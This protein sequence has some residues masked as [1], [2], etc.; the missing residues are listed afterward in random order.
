MQ[1]YV[2]LQ[3]KKS[4]ISGAIASALLM[5]GAYA[6]ENESVDEKAQDVERIIVTAAKRSQTLQET[7]IAVSVTSDIAI[8]QAAI[9]D[10]GDLQTLVPTLR[11][12]SGSRTF[13]QS[14]SIRGFGS[15]TLLGTE[16]SVG[17]FVDGVFRS[18]S[19]GALSDLP[20]LERVEV[21]SGPQSTLFGK[22]ASAGVVSIVTAAPSYE[23]EGRVELTFGKYNQRI[24]DGYVS[25][26]LTDDLAVMVSGNVHKRDGYT[27]AL[28]PNEPDQDNQ[29]RWGLRGQLLWEPTADTT[30]RFIVDYSDVEEVCCY[31]PNVANGPTAA[32]IIALGGIINDD[33]DPFARQSPVFN[34]ATNEIKDSGVS[35]HVEVNFDD[36]VFTSIT[37]YRSNKVK[38]GGNSGGTS[39]PLAINVSTQ[40]TEIDA[41]SQEFRLTSDTEDRL[42]WIVGGF[43]YDEDASDEGGLLYGPGL[44]PYVDLLTGGI[45]ALVEA[46]FGLPT[47]TFLSE[48]VRE[49]T[50]KGQQNTDYSL[51]G[52]LDYQFTDSLT[53]TLGL[54]YTKDKKEAYLSELENNDVFSAINSN[55]LIGA[56]LGGL[57]GLQ[58]RPPVVEFPNAVE[59]G[60]SDDSDTTYQLRLAYK[61][62]DNMNFY[63]SRATG[64]KSSAWDLSNFSRPSRDL[65][66]ALTQAGANS[67]NPRYGSR[68]STPEYSTVNEIGA[69]V[70]YKEFAFNLAV[71]QQTL[72]DFQVR[73][74]DGIDFAQANAGET[75][76]DGFE[77]DMRYSPTENWTFTFAGT[78][79]NP[80]YDDFSNAPPLP[81]SPTD[82][83][84]R[85]L[86]EDLS[87]TTPTNIPEKSIALGAVYTTPLD[88]GELYV[89]ADYQYESEVTISTAFPPTWQP[90]G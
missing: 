24:I 19:T 49:I 46:N 41:L 56:G 90:W 34:A 86:P 32:A 10:I 37:A 12:S 71:F 23:N 25:G 4:A 21:L 87:G 89:R 39:I 22:N 54:N 84:G 13:S 57:V 2:F 77:F 6:Q 64:F 81:T 51:F 78:Y 53:G 60:E 5:S 48:G 31:A 40:G 44:R 26:G 47:G 62:N 67:A 36:F 7:P 27:E 82:E 72:E 61:M 11:V 74:F 14:L 88:F 75:S 85:P 80:V 59:S 69:K 68:L 29:D 58:I 28:L 15:S 33:S 73:T 50:R 70:W 30:V 79:L 9:Q 45:M 38:I 76:V 18:R 8:E 16:P 52:T 63:V 43:Y 1:N 17:V 66:A 3:S 20:K 55:I 65:E 83:F 35:A 42:S